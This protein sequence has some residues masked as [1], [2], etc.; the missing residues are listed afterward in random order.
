MEG[1]MVPV[2]DWALVLAQRVEPDKK[3][4]VM[5]LT[6]E[7]LMRAFGYQ[8]GFAALVLFGGIYILPSIWNKTG[9]KAWFHHTTHRVSTGNGL[10]C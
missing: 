7:W 1:K 4:K 2:K 3:V 6:T 9:M 8:A 10:K 5:G